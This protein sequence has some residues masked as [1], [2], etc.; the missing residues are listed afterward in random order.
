MIKLSNISVIETLRKFK[1]KN[2]PV[3]FLVPTIT[4]L[5]KSIMD[6]TSDVRDFLLNKNIHDYNKQ[7]QGTDSKK[8]INTFLISNNVVVETKTSLYRPD[9]KNGDPRIWIYGLKEHSEPTDLLAIMVEKSELIVIN[10]SKSNL[11]DILSNN[12]QIYK[13]YLQN[14][15]INM[16]A[17]AEELLLKLKNIGKMGFI[18]TM[19]PGGTGVGYTLETLL[20]IEANSSRSPDYKGIEIKSG[21]KNAKRN[22]RTTMFAKTPNWNISKLKSSKEILFKRG[23]VNIED[24]RHK[25]YHSLSTININSYNMKLELDDAQNLL[26]QIYIE[27]GNIEK[28]V[29]W[30]IPVLKDALSK[31]HRETFWVTAKTIGNSNDIEEK[32]QYTK[33]KHTGNLD[34]DA[35]SILLNQGII[36]IDYL[37]KELPNGSSRDKGYLFKI[38]PKD[39][40]LLFSSVNEYNLI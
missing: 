23:K 15:S 28:D 38:R 4:G 9:T 35:F 36:T 17:I 19:R 11:N 16:S 20:E 34:L 31:K 7:T 25:L 2:I 21:R 10:C 32:F 29:S 39:I 13:K 3:C 26:H 22:S 8:L 30:E 12:N 1:E 40:D 14:T 37:I 24:N 18:T 33:V 27:N 5:E 6:A